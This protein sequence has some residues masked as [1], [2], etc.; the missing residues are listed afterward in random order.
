MFKYLDSINTPD[1]IKKLNKKELIALC[2][3]IRH[4]LIDS[5]SK[6]GGHLSSN[7]GTIELTAALHKVFTTPDDKLVWDVGHQC[8]THKIITGRKNK[9]DTLRQKDGLSGFPAPKES[10]HDAFISGHG[11]TAISAA[12]GMANAKKIKGEEGKVI[13]IVGDGAFTGGMVYEGMNNICSLNNLIVV[14]NDNKMS[15]SKNVGSVAQYFTHLRTNP[16]YFAFKRNAQILLDKTPLIGVPI[17]RWLQYLKASLRQR[18]YHSTMFENMGFQYI[19]PINGHDVS[20]LCDIFSAY[21]ND[22]SAPLFMHIETV[23]GKGFTPAEENPGEFHGVSAFDIDKVSDPDATIDDSFS[24]VFGVHLAEIANNN[25]KICAVTAAM[26]Y[27][28]GLQYFYRQHKDRFFDVGMAE[29]HAVTFS[30]GL[31]SSGLKPVVCIYSTFLQR[32]YDQIIHDVHLQN[33]NVLFA[34]DRAGLVPGDGETHQGVYDVAFLSQLPTI[35][36]YSPSNYEELKYWLEELV[37]IDGP[38]AIRYPRGAQSEQMASLKCTGKDYDLYSS[39]NG[40]A[41]TVY[42]SYGAFAQEVLNAA[43]LLKNKNLHA[44]VIKL[45]KIHPLPDGF[46][47]ELLRYKKVIFAEDS[48]QNGGIGEHLISELS[49]LGYSGKFIHKAVDVNRITHASVLELRQGLGLDAESLATY[50]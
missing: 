9:F 32:S 21:K 16:K 47:D 39:N 22:Q 31:A 7:L 3:E 8:Y 19:G 2:D 20:E 50:Y 15:I 12:I 29:Q 30:A 13:A 41:D 17:R 18:L 42:V 1:D 11:N 25:K 33:L 4:F 37:K 49:L 14:L 27:G 24:T 26:K 28:T 6:T 36:V 40:N 46:T 38:I 10:A 5:V 48:V 34:I 44:D 43:E 35:S 45:C 23:K